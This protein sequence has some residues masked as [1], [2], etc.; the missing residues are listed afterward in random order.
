MQ[1]V[2]AAASLSGNRTMCLDA[3]TGKGELRGTSLHSSQ[4]DLKSLVCEYGTIPH[5]T[6]L[7]SIFNPQLHNCSRHNGFWT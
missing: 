2:K 5:V 4:A 1:K 7:D 3:F 6:K